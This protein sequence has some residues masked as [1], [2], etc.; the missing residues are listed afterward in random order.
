M[1]PRLEVEDQLID[2]QARLA[3]GVEG[4][5]RP[6]AFGGKFVQLAKADP[7]GVSRDDFK[8]FLAANQG[9]TLHGCGVSEGLSWVKRRMPRPIGWSTECPELRGPV[10]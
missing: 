5:A 9:G 4:H 6:E 7:E 1:A 8:D 3:A 2:V 10:G